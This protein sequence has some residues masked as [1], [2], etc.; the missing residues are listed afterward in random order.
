[1]TRCRSPLSDVVK[2]LPALGARRSVLLALQL[3]TELDLAHQS[4]FTPGRIALDSVRLQRAGTPF[5]QA[6]F[7]PG[8][9]KRLGPGDEERDM[10][11]LGVLIKG[12]ALAKP[13]YLEG[14]IWTPRG[15]GAARVLGR[16]ADAEVVRA[17]CRA[18]TLIADR[19]LGVRGSYESTFELV[20]DL[21]K[22]AAVAGRIVSR[23][24]APAP[25]VSLASPRP[26]ARA[27]QSSL[28][29]VIINR[30]AA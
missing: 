12:L 27:P 21:G 6:L 2:V 24:R 23:R 1:M 25:V 28:P 5:E 20:G 18:L 17:I 10:R 14:S 15:R 13:M 26:R 30:V 3:A 7:E 22:L 16:R 8:T 19:C 4:G 9:R 11:A 29:K